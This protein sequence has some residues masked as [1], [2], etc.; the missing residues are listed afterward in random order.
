V[1]PNLL[2]FGGFANLLFWIVG[3]S[4]IG[5]RGPAMALLASFGA[6][7]IGIITIVA[8]FVLPRNHW[9]LGSS[10]GGDGFG[11]MAMMI[12]GVVIVGLAFVA[13]IITIVVTIIAE[14]RKA[15]KEQ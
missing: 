11:V 2:I 12:A 15:K 13:L 8:G 10:G 7:A 6:A 3:L 1:I 4:R 5:T 9:A 14:R